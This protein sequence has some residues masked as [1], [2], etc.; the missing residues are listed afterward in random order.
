MSEG[1]P[2]F[3][4][5]IDENLHF[6][7]FHMGMRVSVPCITKNRIH[8]LNSWSGIEEAVRYLHIHEQS[9]HVKVLHDQLRAMR[10]DGGNA[11][12]YSPEDL[13]RAFSYCALSR[14][15]YQKMRNDFKYPSVST[16]TNITSSCSKQTT[17]KFLQNVLSYLDS[18]KKMCVLLHDEVYIKKSM[19]YHGG[20]IFGRV[21]NDP[22]LLADT[23][24]WS[25]V[26]FS[27]RMTK[28]FLNTIP[29]VKMNANF[30]CNEL[31]KTMNDIQHSDGRLRAIICDGNRTNQACFGNFQWSKRGF[32][33]MA[34]YSKSLPV[35]LFRPSY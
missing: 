25:D 27:S 20:K 15:L 14:T 26:N 1:V 35:V 5:Q 17:L 30:R 6:K 28:I 11:K 8:I 23:M 18:A 34:E 13:V 12:I 19:Q 7:A 33:T 21:A 9:H 32:S 29:V 24:A 31:M 4:L 10:P 22:S 2:R 3:V 16:L